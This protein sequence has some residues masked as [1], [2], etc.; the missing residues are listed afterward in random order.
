MELRSD[1]SIRRYRPR[2]GHDDAVK[3]VGEGFEL[4]EYVA[5]VDGE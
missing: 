2:A 5:V 4:S 3:R 1:G